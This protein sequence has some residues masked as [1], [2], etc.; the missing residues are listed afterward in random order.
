MRGYKEQTGYFRAEEETRLFYRRYIPNRGSPRFNVVI[1]HGIGEH[2]GRY[3]DLIEWFAGSGG[4]FYTYDTRGHGLSEGRRGDV[5]GIESFMKDLSIFLNLIR[6]EFGVSRPILLGHS[7]GGLAVLY[8][9]LKYS[10]KSICA[11]VASGPLLRVHPTLSQRMKLI[12]AR[13]LAKKFPHLTLPT[14]LNAYLL[15]HD[16]G[17]VRAYLEDPLV[18]KKIAMGFAVDMIEKGAEA[19]SLA[20]SMKVPLLL[21]HGGADLITDPTGSRHFFHLAA[22]ADKTLKVYPG[23]YH[24]IFNEKGEERSVVLNDLRKWITA[25]FR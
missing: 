6:K 9:A 19:I 18:H 4:A 22:S 5:L 7:L 15:S 14:G 12:F 25:R 13:L 1:H 21:M 3:A 24:E 10:Q 11:V 20:P 23:L 17:I 16:S 8:Y 2:S